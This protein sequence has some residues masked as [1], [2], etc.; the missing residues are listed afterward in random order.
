MSNVIGLLPL[1]F[2]AVMHPEPLFRILTNQFFQSGLMQLGERCNLFIKRRPVIVPLNGVG[3]DEFVA[4]R[5][6][7]D[8]GDGDYERVQFDL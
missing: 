4:A 3:G 8:H 6:S 5:C 7:T 2:P 1:N